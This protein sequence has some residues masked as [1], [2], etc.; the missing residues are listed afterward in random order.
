MHSTAYQTAVLFVSTQCRRSGLDTDLLHAFRL[1]GIL[2]HPSLGGFTKEH[3]RQK[4]TS[5]L[6][7][8]NRQGISILCE[9]S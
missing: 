6:A 2:R 9:R 1:I 4:E 3:L 7:Y 5:N 8:A